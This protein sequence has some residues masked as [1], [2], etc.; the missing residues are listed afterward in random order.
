MKEIFKYIGLFFLIVFSFYY[1]DKISTMLIYKS[2]LMQEINNNK[3]K[4]EKD[5]VNAIIDQDNII[6]GTNGIKINELDSYYRMKKN[7]AFSKTDLVYEEISPIISIEN[8]KNLI[9]SKGRES[10]QM[11]A[12]L[13]NNNKE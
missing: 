10:K 9:I 12:L 6:P 11:V 3:E 8:N 5:F 1:T 7:N 2:D 4:Y 13:L